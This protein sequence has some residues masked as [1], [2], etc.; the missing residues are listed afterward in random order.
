VAAQVRDAAAQDRVGED[1][2]AVERD[3]DR[4]VAEPGDLAAQAGTASR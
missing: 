4:R 2:Q 3:Q 1:A